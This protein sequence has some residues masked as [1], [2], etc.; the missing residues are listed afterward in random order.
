MLARGNRAFTLIELPAVRKPKAFG[1][2]LIE[3]LVVIAIIAILASLLMPALERAR[4]T[5]RYTLECSNMHQVGIAI[6][7]YAHDYAD[8][9]VG[10]N[11]GRQSDTWA[12]RTRLYSG[13]LTKTMD[14]HGAPSSELW[15]CPLVSEWWANGPA[16]F[17][18]TGWGSSL[19]GDGLDV[20]NQALR[21]DYSGWWGDPDNWGVTVRGDG[22][23][24]G[25]TVYRQPNDIGVVSDA[26]GGWWDGDLPNHRVVDG[27]RKPEGSNTLF[28]SGRAAWRDVS[29]LNLT[30]NG[31]QNVWR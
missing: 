6:Q 21:S 12:A 14:C 4:T 8:R 18:N 11:N 26:G 27:V 3:L 1:F 15:G 20:A 31:G 2:T 7:M 22:Y 13:Y 24:F 19:N 10:A 23:Y 5:A 29:K 30:W 17:L 28:L 16:W 9:F 25:G